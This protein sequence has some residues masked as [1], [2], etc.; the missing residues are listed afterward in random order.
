M[1]IFDIFKKK[2][3]SMSHTSDLNERL[4]HIEVEPARSPWRRASDHAVGG[5]TEVGY[6]P[7][8]NLLLVVSSAGR[9]LFDCT[10]GERVARDRTPPEEGGWYDEAGLLALGI[11]PTEEQFI[12]LAGLHGGGLRRVASDGWSLAMV[13]PDWPRQS[14]I[15]QPPGRSVL[16]ERFADGCA[17][18]EDDYELRAFG[19]SD[20]G[21]SFVIALSH[22]LMIYSRP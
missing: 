19:F 7:G 4:R 10:S 21:R 13:A 12:R 15:I 8:S 6:V 5:L 1:A 18:I 2:G 3:S 22:S 11:G 14:I 17:K 9:G 20:T 16:I